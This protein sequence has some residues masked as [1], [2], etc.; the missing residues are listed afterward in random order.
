MRSAG[1][2]PFENAKNLARDHRSGRSSYRPRSG[3]NCDG[4]LRN[5]DQAQPARLDLIVKRDANGSLIGSNR[6]RSSRPARGKPPRRS[7]PRRVLV[8]LERTA[9]R[10]V[11]RADV[12]LSR[13]GGGRRVR[14]VLQGATRKEY[15]RAVDGQA[16]Y[17]EA[18][19]THADNEHGYLTA[20]AGASPRIAPHGRLRYGS[21]RAT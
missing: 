17:G 2:A 4:Y 13:A 7:S 3:N 14:R 19:E 16:C 15:A 21:M 12:E 5:P 9:A 10:A 11:V 8:Q 20:F 6:R 18:H 1:F